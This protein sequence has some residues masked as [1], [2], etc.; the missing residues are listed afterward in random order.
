MAISDTPFSEALAIPS[1]RVDLPALT[2]L[3]STFLQKSTEIGR[4]RAS[5][6]RLARLLVRFFGGLLLY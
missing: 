6:V 5:A 4:G 2:Y 3:A 1:E